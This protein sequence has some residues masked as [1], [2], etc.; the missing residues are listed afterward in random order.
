M[1]IVSTMVGLSIAGAA[2]PSMLTMSIAPFEAQK[3]A[4]N[5]GTAESRA[6][7]YAAANEGASSLADPP[8]GCTRDDTNTPAYTITCEHGTG[9]YIQS[10]SRSFRQNPGSN[11]GNGTG[12]QGRFPY[13]APPGFTSTECFAR[14]NWGINT[15]AF[16]METYTWVADSCMPSTI[17]GNTDIRYRTSDITAWKYNINNWNGWGDHPN[18]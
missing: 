5:L 4:Q 2:A 9:K 1:N 12:W 6:V 11:T 15:D 3:R 10:V 17:R 14:D 16:D 18:Y 13:P 8:A 7:T